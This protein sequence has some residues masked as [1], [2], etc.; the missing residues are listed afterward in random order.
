MVTFLGDTGRVRIPAGIVDLQS[1]LRWVHSDDVEEKWRVGWLDGEVWVDMSK[2]QIFTHVAVKT[3]VTV[4]LGGLV[5]AN[6]SGRFF[7]DGLMISSFGLP[8]SVRAPNTTLPHGSTAGS[9]TSTNGVI[10]VRTLPRSLRV[11]IGPAMTM[12]LSGWNWICDL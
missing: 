11:L 4:V 2:E 10:T 3:E 8:S 6:K 9:V 1:F 7:T 12:L 5:K